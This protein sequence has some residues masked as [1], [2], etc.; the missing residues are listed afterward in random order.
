MVRVLKTLRKELTPVQKCR[1]WTLH[2]DGN[3]ISQIHIKTGYPHSTITTFLNRHTLT[4][5]DDFENKPGRGAIRKITPRGER[6]LLRTVNLEP[7]MTLK[8]L[9]SPSKSGHKLN[10]H[11]VASILKLNG[12]AKRRPRKKPFLTDEHKTRRRAHYRA[13]KAMKR[14]NRK[15]Y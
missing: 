13:E 1:I 15:V 5:T 12:K 10:H 4:P 3:N 2:E 7:R 8:S 11:T 9:A 14:D 6:H